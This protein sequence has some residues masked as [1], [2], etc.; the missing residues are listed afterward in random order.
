MNEHN[1]PGFRLIL[2]RLYKRYGVEF[3]QYREG[4]ITRRL[5]RRMAATGA[6]NYNEYAD[7]IENDPEEAEHLLQEF[8]I[9]VSRFFRNHYMFEILA[10]DIL[11]DLFKS[12]EKKRDRTIRIWCAGCA[13]GEEPYSVAITLAEYLKKVEKASNYH[14]NI[15]GTDIDEDA[16][17]KARAG[18]YDLASVT[19]VKKGILDKYFIYSADNSYRVV[20][21]IKDAVIFCHHNITSQ[22]RKSPAAGIVANYDLIFCRNLLIYFSSPLQDR[23][24][25]NLFG[26][27]NPGGYLFLGK[28]EIIPESLETFFTRKYAR[29]KIYQK[30]EYL[31]G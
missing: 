19:E 6:A 2:Q 10:C 7:T 9:K 20:D 21:S 26:S 27:L 25:Q 1:D 28:S 24:F 13:F 17:V 3:S 5:D 22:K 12:K 8:T 4:T 15:F 16:L 14:V 30:R 23:A 18:V 31:I 29:K 11:P